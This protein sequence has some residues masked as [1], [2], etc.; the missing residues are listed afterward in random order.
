VFL[1][2]YVVVLKGAA[3]REG[4]KGRGKVHLGEEGGE[5]AEEVLF[6]YLL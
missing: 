4:G 5:E 2:W 6:D 3:R 1:G